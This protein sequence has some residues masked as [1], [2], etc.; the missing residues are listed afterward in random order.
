MKLK[1]LKATEVEN[2][3]MNGG[4]IIVNSAI[5]FFKIH[6]V[7]LDNEIV[8]TLRCDTYFKWLA[9]KKL[10]SEKPCSDTYVLNKC[11]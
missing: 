7:A 1:I 4:K 5:T 10:I 6:V 9:S 8:G 11:A 3:L 2:I